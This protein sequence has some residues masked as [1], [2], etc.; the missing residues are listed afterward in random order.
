MCPLQVEFNIIAPKYSRAIIVPAGIRWLCVI[1]LE[2]NVG[3]QEPD[4][5]SERQVGGTA[6]TFQVPGYSFK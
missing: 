1:A 3:I 2:S 4:L 5:S 6:G